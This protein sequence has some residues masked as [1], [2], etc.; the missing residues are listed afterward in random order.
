ME[1]NNL[2]IG[3]GGVL[4]IVGLLF[5]ILWSKMKNLDERLRACPDRP[6]VRDLIADKLEGL[7]TS[8]AAIQEDIRDIK[9]ILERREN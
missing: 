2:L 6:E 5:G 8:Q 7:K 3:L 4:S 9:N 1:L